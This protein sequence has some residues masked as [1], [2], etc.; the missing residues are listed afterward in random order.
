MSGRFE[1]CSA[2]PYSRGS[3]NNI[4]HFGAKLVLRDG[5]G[6]G[7]LL[8]SHPRGSGELLRVPGMADKIF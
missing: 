5:L 2:T 6:S 3:D 7:G 1:G 4:G 8:S